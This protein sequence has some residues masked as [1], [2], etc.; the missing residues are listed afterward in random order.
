MAARS[1]Q[2]NDWY[3]N[4][5]L[6]KIFMIIFIIFYFADRYNIIEYIRP[7]KKAIDIESQKKAIQIDSSRLLKVEKQKTIVERE[8]IRKIKEVRAIIEDINFE[9]TSIDTMTFDEKVEL[10]NNIVK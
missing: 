5:S 4:L 1:K 6:F 8:V 9:T 7:I 2:S 3:G 10:L